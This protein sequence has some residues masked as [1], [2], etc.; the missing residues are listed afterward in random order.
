MDN[1]DIQ[2]I[3]Q[4]SQLFKC[5]NQQTGKVEPI[6]LSPGQ[7]EI[8]NAIV[9]RS[10]PRWHVQ[11]TTQYGKSLTVALATLL[12]VATFPEKWAII[13]P[14]EKQARIIMGYIIEHIFD[15][16]II[17]SQFIQTESKEKLKQE[18]S[19]KR[20]TFK[21]GG[22]VFILSADTKNKRN[23]GEGLLGFGAANIILD[24]SSLI[25]N[26]IYAKIFRMLG[27]HAD[28]FILEIGNPYKRN[29]FLDSFRDDTYKKIHITYK[30][31]IAEGRLTTSFIEEM[32][33][34]ADFDVLYA[35][36]FPKEEE[37]ND[38][39]WIRIFY[40]DDIHRAQK[41]IRP[42]VF[43]P[44]VIGV[45]VNRGGSNQTVFVIRWSNHA[46][47]ISEYV[48]TNLN[49]TAS[50]LCKKAT[51]Y[52][53]AAENIYVDATGVGGGLVD[54]MAARG[55]YVNGVNMSERAIREDKYINRRAEAY[56]LTSEWLK[57]GNTLL[58]H[59]NWFQLQNI[60][61]QVR[62]TNGKWQI[63]SKQKILQ[64]GLSSPDAADAL[65]LTFCAGDL[66]E[67]MYYNATK[68]VEAKR[69]RQPVYE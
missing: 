24:E 8:F 32:K 45:D 69:A 4:L 17:E 34:R 27:G 50:L 3:A 54:I 37:V 41:E 26:D 9:T 29:H 38:E 57:K 36:Q 19:K 21:G 65:S 1:L 7:Q 51:E 40:E 22:E 25:P 61:A 2:N 46:E 62:D 33:Q 30:Q 31:A 63:I 66:N 16:P 53:V 10:H 55:W 5:Y 64:Q 52:G 13:A 56:I 35:V 11:T 42:P 15:N 59:K 68:K 12:R 39:G 28:N 49:E 20:I 60:T 44:R 48:S 14:T 18:K 47:I 67:D 58:K 23:S 6:I 43:G